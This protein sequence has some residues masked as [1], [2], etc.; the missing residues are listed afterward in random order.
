M[1]GKIKE[2]LV[3]NES[4]RHTWVA[5]KLEALAQGKKLLDAGC[6]EQRYRKHCEHL[7]YS[8]QDFGEYTGEGKGLQEKSWRYGTLDYIGDV[9]NVKEKDG[10]FDAILCTEV[11]EHIPYPNEAVRE[12]SRLLKDGGELILTAPYACL[13]HFQP[14][15]FYSGFSREWYE[16]TLKENGLDIIE[17]TAN[18][19]YFSFLFLEGVRGIKM[20]RNPLLKM[21]YALAMLP[22][23]LVELLVVKLNRDESLVFGYHVH[24]VKS[25]R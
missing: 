12:F 3:P 17:I 19:D 2:W 6:G 7:T 25:G 23:L 15:F 24:A 13:P 4:V 21:L 9:W 10:H 5:E 14:Y 18:G 20:I 8:G 16:F 22:K 1:L 11:F